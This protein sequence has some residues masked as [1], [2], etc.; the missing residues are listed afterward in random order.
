MSRARGRGGDGGF[1]LIESIVTISLITVVMTALASF[2]LNAMA[3]TN[4]QRARQTATQLANSAVE[5]LR[6][7][8]ASDLVTGHDTTSVS[9][10]FAAAPAAV[11]PWLT[12]M[13]PATD[14]TAPAGSGATARIPT[15]ALTQTL[16]NVAYRVN[17]YLGWCGV[18]TDGSGADCS[19][20][21]VST[22]TKYLRAVVAVTWPEKRCPASTCSYVT[23]TLIS[24]AD[25]PTFNLNQTPP[26][27]PVVTNPGAKTSAVGDAV[28]LQLAVNDGTGVPT[29]TWQVT[30]GA[31]PAGL[32]LNPAGLISGM[33]TATV[34]N[35]SVTVT[36]TDAFLRTATATFTWTVVPP[37][38]I[39][40]PGDQASLTGS[41]ITPLTLTAT[42][43]S[44]SPYAWSDPNATLPPGL[45]MSTV[46]GQGKVSGTPT[47]PGTFAV[48]LTVKDAAARSATISLTWTISY[49]PLAAA[50]PGA[51]TSTLGTAIAPLQLGASGGSGTYTWSGA[52]TLPGGLS[53]TAGGLISGAPTTTGTTTAT[54]TVTDGAVVRTV[55][56]TWS[57]VARPAITSPGNQTTTVGATINVTL[58]SSCPDA[59]C[60]YTLNNGPATLSVTAGVITGTVTSAAQTFGSVSVTVRDAAGST[61]TTS[62]FT[63]TVNPAPTMTGP[64][65][66]TVLKGSPGSLDV[67]A[68]VNGGTGPYTYSAGGLPVWLTLNPAT[69]MITGTAPAAK[70]VTS[71]ITVRATD[72]AGVSVTSAAFKWIV[73]DLATSIIDQTTSKSTSVSLDLDSFTTGGTAPYTYAITG[74]PSWLSLNGSTGVLSGTSPNAVSITSGIT[75]TVTDSL[76][77][78]I[79]SAP[80]KWSVTDLRWSTIPLQLSARGAAASL[81][82]TAYDSGGTAPYTYAAT[83]L[84]PGLTINAATGVISGTPTTSNTYSVR[85]TV[86]DGTGA[87][88]TSSA[89]TWWVL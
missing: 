51:Q 45:A 62:A 74:K 79:T 44:G 49:P 43:G 38:A 32:A 47:T 6:G 23:A 60:S 41:P 18:P 75:I 11:R 87:S 85:V 57:V 26:A 21:A 4:H 86:T 53:M 48:Q 39:T 65:N 81:N 9:S 7:L 73:T 12:S 77:A 58:T 40:D 68:L 22:G 42:G 50:N 29:Y 88:V 61:A 34:T 71:G 54:L 66:Q 16:N 28:G 72:S 89:F 30:A 70:S 5:T 24:A 55:S 69:G 13:D 63:W 56:F 59:P 64:G 83:G 36:V 27:A 82:V 35:R 2:F 67:S 52:A 1:V 10:Q 46:S 25:D 3:S 17:D 14:S 19:Q 76:G 80:F 37:L 31:L 8:H 78:V 33:P 20:A 15:V 84:P